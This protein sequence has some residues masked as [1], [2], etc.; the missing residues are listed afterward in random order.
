M[1]EPLAVRYAMFIG[2]RSQYGWSW[3]FVALGV[4]TIIFAIVNG[5]IFPKSTFDNGFWLL[6]GFIWLL[7]ALL[8]FERRSFY[9]IIEQ[10]NHRIADL[11][12]KQLR[13]LNSADRE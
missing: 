3:V 13:D 5:I 2:K 9:R 4:G 7:F 1:K 10:Q 12:S 11:E 6:S 8:Q